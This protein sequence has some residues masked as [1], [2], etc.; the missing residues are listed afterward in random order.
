MLRGRLVADAKQV[1]AE[2]QFDDPR[3]LQSTL[4]V[5]VIWTDAAG[6]AVLG[7]AT[8][9]V[10]ALPAQFT[11]SEAFVPEAGQS[12]TTAQLDAVRDLA[13]Q[14]VNQMEAWW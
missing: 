6:G 11:D 3:V 1:I 13:R 5:E 14:I 9:P 4:Q 12:I 2:N 7:S 8:V 10:G